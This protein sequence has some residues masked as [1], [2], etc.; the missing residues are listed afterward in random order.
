MKLNSD[1]QNIA[2]KN[3]CKTNRRKL[4]ESCWLWIKANWAW[5]RTRSLAIRWLMFVVTQTTNMSL[6]I[7]QAISTIIGDT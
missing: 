1:D 4:L 5:N 3:S 6:H 2:K 7:K